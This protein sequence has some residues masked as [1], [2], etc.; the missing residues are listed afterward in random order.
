[1]RDMIVEEKLLEEARRDPSKLF[2]VVVWGG[3]PLTGVKLVYL[4]EEARKV[5]DKMTP[6]IEPMFAF[7]PL[8]ER[9]KAV[10]PT[11]SSFVTEIQ[12]SQLLEIE[13]VKP[14]LIYRV[15]PVRTVKALLNMSVPLIGGN[16]AWK[17]GYE[18]DDFKI[19]V[20][21]TGVDA[22]YSLEGRVVAE[23]N[24]VEDEDERDYAGH[25][26]HVAAIA[27]G[28]EEIYRGVAPRAK[29]ISAKTLNKEGMGSDYTVALGISWSFDAGANI[30]NL[31]L[32][33]EG[34][35]QD[36]LCRLCNALAERGIVVV[37]AA[38]NEGEKGITSPGLAEKVITVGATDKRGAVAWY[39]SRDIAGHG[40]PDVVA[41]GGLNKLKDGTLLP[42]NEGIIS[43]RSRYSRSEA[44]PDEF[45]TSMSGTSMATPHVSGAAALI[46]EAL[47]RN[48]FEGN[49]H[50]AV[51]KLLKETA[52][53]L[54]EP[55]NAQ[56]AGLIDIEAAIKRASSRT[57]DVEEIERS[58]LS[59]TVGEIL[60]GI[61]R[62][63]IR[64]TVY[65]AAS[66]LLDNLLRGRSVEPTR[67]D[68][69]AVVYEVI[70]DVEN[71]IVQLADQYRRGLISY[72]KYQVRMSQL[73]SMISHLY[74]L[75]NNLIK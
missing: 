40:K 60:S 19:A 69:T 7:G 75:L 54:G 33:G 52:K 61:S 70:A 39:S 67:E 41:P 44:Y 10:F 18:G 55:R 48:G 47:K 64:G 29:V 14:L 15:E 9:I 6:F 62:E 27:A 71:Q 46:A 66:S 30:V 1:M 74:N 42:P 36:L 51:K 20:V 63:I 37:A 24:F 8:A 22:Y 72:Q 34:H 12:G 23:R 50:Y 45:H 73:N 2:E 25:E 38:G 17:L 53:D 56:G 11:L 58:Y 32:G 26:T 65:A 31:S 4:A 28:D 21:G 13:R 57:M 49:L 5:L 3:V 35:P 16:K 43:L 59:S 68:L